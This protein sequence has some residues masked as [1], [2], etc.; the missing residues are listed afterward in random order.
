MSQARYTAAQPPK[1]AEG[2][3][4]ERVTPISHLHGAN[5]MRIGADGRLYIAQCVGSAISALDVDT[6][7]LEVISGVGSEI[8]APDDLDIDARGNLYA[9]EFMDG[10]V[11]VR[12]PNGRTRVLRDD[13]PNANGITFHQGRLFI[14]ECRIG[15]RLLE[16]DLNGG[17]PRVV[18]DNL[19]LPNALCPG[20]DGYLYFPLVAASEIWRVHPDGGTPERVVAGLAHPVAVKFDAKGF[21]ISPQ[22][23]TGEVLRI[24]PRNGNRTLLAQVG[25]CLDNL[26]FKGERLF[27]SHM[28]DGRITEIF[29]DGRSQ[30]VLPGGLQFPYDIAASDDGQIYVADMTALHGLSPDGKCA[31]LGWMFA[32]GFPGTVRGLAVVSGGVMATTTDGRVVLYKP[33]SK[34]HE[35]LAQGLDQ[36]YGVAVGPR[37][38]IVVAER[39]TGQVHTIEAGK[40][41]VLATGLDHPMGVAFTADGECLVSEESAGRVVKIVGS[42]TETVLDGLQRPQGIAIR[43]TTLYIVDAG[44][45]AVIAFDLAKRSRSTIGT[46]LPVGAPPG[47]V[48]KP[49]LGTRPFS[50]PLGPYAGITATADGTLYFAADTEGSVMALRPLH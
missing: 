4:L 16:L 3:K 35:V 34:E 42:G 7:A 41:S 33:A 38:A 9:T 13:V 24:D 18:A 36:I 19:Q 22:S 14:D 5:G 37:G 20:P 44:A 8:I 29:S 6:G 2:W 40:A 23:E 32:P 43:G 25:P 17:A 47:V 10:R 26:A 15:G 11:S 48:P 46:G 31:P 28:I 49:L 45:H 50:G 39:A 21:I 27:V 12:E 1:I 30:V